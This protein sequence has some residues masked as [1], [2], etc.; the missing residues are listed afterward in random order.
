MS[1]PKF[2]T[3]RLRN[4]KKTV[5]DINPVYLKQGL[6]MICGIFKNASGL[7]NGTLLVEE[8]TVNQSNALLKA[9]LLGSYPIKE[10]R[11][12]SLNSSGGV[13]STDFLDGLSDE[14][15]QSFHADQSLSRAYRLTGKRGTSDIV[16]GN[17][18]EAGHGDSPSKNPSNCVNCQGNQS[19]NSKNA[20]SFSKRR[21]SRSLEERMISPSLKH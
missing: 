14:A 19:S 10:E 21:A 9:S 7:R 11:H 3:L 12:V 17:C 6:D 20:C 18:G 16:C 2:L 8:I 4:T 1:A 5:E 13:I 15:V